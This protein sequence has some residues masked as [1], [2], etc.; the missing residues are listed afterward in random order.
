MHGPSSDGIDRCQLPRELLAGRDRSDSLVPD[1]ASLWVGVAATLSDV[2]T[3]RFAFS[4]RGGIETAALF[5]SGIPFDREALTAARASRRATA[6]SA[7]V[8]GPLAQSS[9]CFS[10]GLA[11]NRR[12][13]RDVAR[14]GKLWGGL[15]AHAICVAR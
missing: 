8:L 12:L 6:L 2:P 11:V 4:G 5:A 1:C 3:S 10:G 15:L 13:N 9:R 7:K 14:L